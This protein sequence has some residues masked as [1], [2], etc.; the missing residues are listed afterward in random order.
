[1]G[2][3]E[4]NLCICFKFHC[5]QF[6]SRMLA[7]V[8]FQ[9]PSAFVRHSCHIKKRVTF[10]RIWEA[11]TLNW[12]LRNRWR[13]VGKWSGQSTAEGSTWA[14]RAALGFAMQKVWSSTALTA[15]QCFTEAMDPAR[16][17]LE[18]I[19]FQWQMLLD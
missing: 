15:L 1:M 11:E 17:T 18:T 14:P 13:R 4:E 6:L 10:H 5:V 8:L 9:P 12:V 2:D 19:D 7:D 3:P 16:C